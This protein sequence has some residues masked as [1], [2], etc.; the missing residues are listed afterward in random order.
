MKRASLFLFGIA[1][2]F[3][4]LHSCRHDQQPFP[5]PT[6]EHDKAYFPVVPGAWW[7]FRV[8]SVVY[9][10]AQSVVQRDTVSGFER[11]TIGDTAF[12]S[13]D[14]VAFWLLRRY[15]NLG[16]STWNDLPPWWIATNREGLFIN[17]GNLLFQKLSFPVRKGRS[18][19]GNAA[20]YPNES[21]YVRDQ[22]LELAFAGWKYR[23]L[24]DPRPDTVGSTTFDSVVHV[25]EADP[26]DI[27]GLDG[28]LYRWAQSKYAK[29]I[30][31]VWKR[32]V[33][34]DDEDFSS[35]GK[36]IYERADE[37]FIL[38]MQLIQYF[39]P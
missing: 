33:I 7:E 10:I 8:D 24:T 12:V 31:P 29:H 16:D 28:P 9:Y 37:G 6:D 27:A 36:P 22:E 14:M 19:D 32:W 1:G 18:W 23:Y 35:N 3:A 38:E 4:L 34:L 39:I 17:E 25:Q 2:V 11:W 13:D 21:F 30:G 5:Q 15:R 26:E 20:I